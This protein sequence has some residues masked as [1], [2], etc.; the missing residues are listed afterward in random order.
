VTF[1]VRQE[2]REQP[3]WILEDTA[4]GARA[5]VCPILGFNCFRWSVGGQERLYA[6]PQFL[7]GSPPTRSGIPILFPFPNRIRGGMFTWEGRTYQLPIND[8]A[9]RNAI[10]GFAVRRPWR[11]VDHGADASSAWITGEFHGSVDA[12]DCVALWPSDYRIRVTQRLTATSL[13][14]EAIVDNPGGTPL[15][16]GLGYHHYF[17]AEEETLVQASARSFWELDE[18]LPT[19]RKLPVDATGDLN[20]PRRFADLKFDDVLTDLAA[21]HEHDGLCL[22]GSVTGSSGRVELWTSPSFRELVAFTPPHRQAVCLEPYTCVTDAINLQ[23]RGIDAGWR[24]LPAEEAWEGAV[25]LRYARN[26]R[27]SKTRPGA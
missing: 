9:K 12:P 10:H 20:E 26:P 7:S 3:V 17:A 4:T 2:R 15:P 11:V 13:R 16:F 14:T 8:P 5:Q 21:S 6:D 22:R 24:V 25:E 23:Q 18:T 27:G 1:Q 19:G